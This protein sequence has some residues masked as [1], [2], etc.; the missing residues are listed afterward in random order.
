MDVPLLDLREQYR[1]IRED[2]RR[3]LDEVCD[4]Q[5]FILGPR[6]EQFEREVAAYCGTAGGCGMSSGTDALLACLMA[7]EVGPGHEVILPSY[8]FF[9]TGGVVARL[10]ATPVLVDIDPL[11]FNL[12]PAAVAARITPRTRAIIVVHLFG[13]PA[14]MTPLLA[15]ARAAG[16]AVI[17]DACQAIGAEYRGSRVGS[18]GDYG[19]FSFFPSKNLGGFGDGGMVVS[20]NP[21][22]LAK[23]RL[24]RNHGMQPKYYHHLVGGNFRLDALQA[25]VLSVKLPHLDAWTAARQANAVHYG[26]L[27]AEA[28]PLAVTP[29]VAGSCTR[30]VFNQYTIRVPASRRQAV[31]DGLRAASVGCEVYYPVP[32][33]MQPC[34]AGLGHAPG[35][36]PVSAAAAAESLSIPVYP[37]LTPAQRE[38]VVATVAQALAA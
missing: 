32:L 17:E 25:A 12:D 4:A 9:A 35:D 14:D 1:A 11:T 23:V 15:A 36:L 2:V 3:V 10:G 16:V 34:F 18:L 26:R 37:E 33:H 38:H 8:T 6:V 22:K 27:F 5:H 30:H 20:N 13:Q 19:C 29:A 28:T 21:E 7:E 31:W 24:L